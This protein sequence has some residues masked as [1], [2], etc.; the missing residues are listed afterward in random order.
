[1]NDLFHRQHP[2]GSARLG[3]LA[4]AQPLVRGSG[5]P[6]G[7]LDGTVLRAA[8]DEPRLLIGGAGSRKF[9][10]FGA[11]QVL[12][13]TTRSMFVLDVGGQY[14][15]V[16]WHW[17]IALGRDA[18]A[19]NPNRIGVHRHSHALN[20][21]S[22]VK[23]DEQLFANALLTTQMLVPERPQAGENSWVRDEEIRWLRA[24]LLYLVLTHGYAT[25]PALWNLVQVI[26]N[27]DDAL[28]S[29][30]RA[31]EGMPFGVGSTLFEIY[32]KKRG[33]EK[34]Y[35]AVMGQIKTDLQ[36][37]A[38]PFMQDVL[39]TREDFLP[40]LADPA[41]KVAVY[42]KVPPEMTSVWTSFNRVVVGSAMLHCQRAGKG[43]RP[44]FHLDEAATCGGAAFIKSAVSQNRKYFQTQLVYQSHG[45]LVHLFGRA[46]A[47]EIVS[48]CGL[49]QYMGGG[50][51]D[52]ETA[53]SLAE[54]IGHATI[55]VDDPLTQAD[56]AFRARAAWQDMLVRGADPL[57]A[58]ARMRHEMQQSRQQKKMRRHV[59][60]PAE[61]LS[62]GA[63]KLIVLCR[64]LGIPPLL[65]DKLPD[66]WTNPALAGMY[67]PD[68][69]FPP[70][71][72]VTIRT[73]FGRTATRRMMR[74]PPPKHLAQLPNV[75]TGEI[76]FV[77]GYR[78]W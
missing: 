38:D 61:I 14:S 26:D 31:A 49:Q 36:W 28:E 30:G 63:N 10:A 43:A 4:D 71:D 42:L 27:D 39:D 62:L 7:L 35:G 60:D 23:V 58:L 22:I 44:Y 53:T 54:S 20:P 75:S 32:R 51:R 3:A 73:R 47:Q 34:E 72:R 1:M 57:E 48:S 74:Q 76:T 78:T 6:Q 67:G 8:G 55:T 19:I 29:I 65:C 68:P 66:Y 33:S 24:P 40:R 41:A 11:Y 70:L 2:H 50:I 37:L 18:Y 69:L 17:N 15:D 46:G 45:Q 56:R 16:T 64:G 52:L 59:L 12:S 21:I 9:T 5:P 25:L 13:P 77:E